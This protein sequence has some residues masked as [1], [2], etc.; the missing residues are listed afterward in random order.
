MKKKKKKKKSAKDSSNDA[1]AKFCVCGCVCFFFFFADFFVKAYVVGT[2]LN[3][4]DIC[5][6]KGVN[7]KY[8]AVI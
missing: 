6:Y 5:L 2:H 7:K 3:C 4:I 8:M 1:Y